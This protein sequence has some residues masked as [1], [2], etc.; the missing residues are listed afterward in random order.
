MV[1]LEIEVFTSPTCP[2]CPAAVRAT[3]DLLKENPELAEKISWKH[4][5]TA[6][7]EGSRKATAYGIRSVPTIIL[8]N[9]KGQK[10]GFVGAPGQKTYL[11]IVNEML[12]V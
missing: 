8:T 6:S 2:H 9:S 1:E 12:K 10:G 11:N 4:L 3:E 5:S 7:A